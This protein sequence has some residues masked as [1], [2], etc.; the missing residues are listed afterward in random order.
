MTCQQTYD[1]DHTLK[2]KIAEAGP[3]ANSKL[4][5]RQ[6]LELQDPVPH[7][8]RPWGMLYLRERATIYQ[9]LQV[10]FFSFSLLITDPIQ[11]RR[12]WFEKGEYPPD[13][14]LPGNSL[15]K[16]LSLDEPEVKEEQEPD[17]R[18]IPEPKVAAEAEPRD[19]VSIL[20]NQP[21]VIDL[22]DSDDEIPLPKIHGSK[23][24]R[25]S[26]IP[27]K[28]P[29]IKLE[30]IDLCSRSLSPAPSPETQVAKKIKLEVAEI[31]FSPQFTQEQPQLEENAE[32][33]RLKE[34]DER[35]EEE[36]RTLQR[37]AELQRKSNERKARMAALGEKKILLSNSCRKAR[38]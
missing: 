19:V 33:M 34:E 30:P 14:R 26:A 16:S 22:D 17:E 4:I 37:L 3:N 25:P 9:E 2:Q 23:R 21:A 38:E 35:A 15:E 24:Q 36:M 29:T 1:K 11:T 6:L 8:W 10:S 12:K 13:E 27:K 7:K 5:Q 28:Q 18:L 31:E 20:Q 32:L